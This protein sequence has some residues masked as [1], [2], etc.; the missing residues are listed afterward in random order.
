[1]GLLGVLFIIVSDVV[2]V[3]VVVNFGWVA[4]GGVPE[5]GCWG[6]GCGFGVG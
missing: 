1:M 6:T 5:T 4:N 2:I 3:V